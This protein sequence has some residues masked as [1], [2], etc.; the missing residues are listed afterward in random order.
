MFYRA[1]AVAQFHYVTL[2]IMLTQTLKVPL[3]PNT[4]LTVTLT[5]TLTHTTTTTMVLRPFFRDHPGE[6]R[7]LLDFMVQGE[8][9]RPDTQ[10][11]RQGATPSGVPD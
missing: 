1:F 8:I 4:N 5:A 2:T 7:E 6:H 11:I 10:T 9:N 3:C